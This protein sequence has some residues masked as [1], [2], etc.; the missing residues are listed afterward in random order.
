MGL[1]G[2]D[3]REPPCG[4][5][6]QLA[7]AGCHRETDTAGFSPCQADVKGQIVADNRSLLRGPADQPSGQGY[8]CHGPYA[9]MTAQ[10][11]NDNDA[12]FE[13]AR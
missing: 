6:D 9:P 13:K 5:E 4:I 12:A 2:L 3:G 1:E 10:L 8:L 11:T 7:G